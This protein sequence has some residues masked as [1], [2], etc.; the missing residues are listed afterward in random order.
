MGSVRRCI[1][2]RGFANARAEA[3]M[4]DRPR[5]HTQRPPPGLVTIEVHRPGCEKRRIVRVDDEAD[6]DIRREADWNP[7]SAAGVV[8]R[9]HDGAHL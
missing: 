1:P 7:M 8:R 2:V 4:E 5:R 9:G 3:V 6:L